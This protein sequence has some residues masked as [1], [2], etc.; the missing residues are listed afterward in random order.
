MLNNFFTSGGILSKTLQTYEPRPEQQE[1]AD[2]I[3]KAL[4]AERHLIVEA[5]T[6]VG[7]SLAYLVPLIKWI[8]DEDKKA[9]VSTYT[10][11]LQRQLVEK[12]LPFLKEHVF[13]DLRF[14]LCFGSENYLCVRRLKQSRKFGLFD[15]PDMQDMDTLLKWANTTETGLRAEIDI[16]AGLW[17]KV[18]RE[19]DLCHGNICKHFRKC[20]YQKAKAVERQAHILVTNH[21][22]FFAHAVSGYNVLPPFSAVVFDEAHELEGVAS[23]YLGAELSN[24]SLTRLFDS[25]LSR[26]GKGLLMR[27]KWLPENDFS[28]CNAVLNTVRLQ[29]NIF[30]D[31]LAGKLEKSGVM[32]IYQK[33]FI[34][35][36]IS[37]PLKSLINELNNIYHASGD[38]NEKIEILAVLNRCKGV[39]FSL[40]AVIMQTLEEHVYWAERDEKRLKIS[41]T[42]IKPA[43][44]L[45][46]IFDNMDT[47]VFTS[48]TLAADGNFN[49]IKERLGLWDADALLL[50]SPFNYKEQSLLY[51]PSALSA[52]GTKEFEEQL[53]AKIKEILEITKGRTLVL[54]TSYNTLEKAYAE[55]N[56][57]GLRILR[58][59]ETDSY[60]LIERFKQDNNSALFGTNTF[61]QGI[62]VPGDDLQCV[63]I[64]K[65]PFAVPGEPVTEARIE[66]IE[67]EGR[68]AFLE[69][70][71]PQAIILLKQGFGRLIRTKT[72]R[73]IVAILDSRLRTKGYGM[74]FLKSLPECRVTAD[75]NQ[76]RDFLAVNDIIG[77]GAVEL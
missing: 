54:F 35:D 70:Q 26:H 71:V 75:L 11:A 65:L 19:S 27:L 29:A 48:A 49:Y 25:I 6:G 18:C 63:I 4:R 36:T 55:I 30:F 59:G 58:Q 32:R 51:I 15:M 68:Q 3:D 16:K 60:R 10:K 38:E 8:F 57:E 28:N 46:E 7:K 9:A 24:Y 42:P 66:A 41:A 62:D 23:D 13:K 12:E 73:G 72:D 20:F 76:L 1:M 21:H 17:H 40:E 52:P 33:G 53:I 43:G 31:E 47:A 77:A 67:K 37:E 64:A 39:L 56:I 14:A 2:A 22:L 5:G 69:Y 34:A 74:Q 61:W 44:L 50:K 45:K